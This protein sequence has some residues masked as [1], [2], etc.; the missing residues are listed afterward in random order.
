MLDC[1]YAGAFERGMFSRADAEAH[2]QDS[3]SGLERTAGQRG[4]AVLTASSAVEYAFE[5]DRLV[6]SAGAR[7]SAEKGRPGPS[8]FTGALVEGLRTGAADLNGDGEIGLSELAEYVSQRIRRITPHQNPQ[9]WIFGAQGDLPIGKAPRR[10]TR[11]APLPPGLAAAAASTEP[12]RRLWA[13]TDLGSTA[14]GADVALARTACAALVE[15]RRDDSRRVSEAAQSAWSAV[16]PRVSAVRV[17]L[18]HS[19]PGAPRPAVLLPVEGPPVVRAT[20]EAIACR[21]A[22]GTPPRCPAGR[23]AGDGSPTSRWRRPIRGGR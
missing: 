16:L 15:L 4:R 18:G 5:G 2:V 8:L 14:R 12:E 19:D 1:C 13:V 10:V 17:D 6:A 20:L 11:P 7:S 23:R 22:S 3:F 21:R 9:L